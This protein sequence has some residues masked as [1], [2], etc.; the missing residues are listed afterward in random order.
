MSELRQNDLGH[1]EVIEPIKGGFAERPQADG[2]AMP[3]PLPRDDSRGRGL[4]F[5]ALGVLLIVA[6]GVVFLLPQ[7]VE[8]QAARPEPVA[9]DSTEAVDTEPT[10]P[11]LTPE[12]LEQLREEAEAL[13]AEL[14][15]QQARLDTLSAESWGGERWAD[16]VARA[17]VGDDAYLA[18]A[19]QDAVP[20][21]SDTLEIGET[22]LTQ[23]SDIINA[24][25]Q[26][27]A[28]ALEAGNAALATEQFSLV[29]GIEPGNE[30]A[31]R[32]LE[33]AQ[34]LPDVLDF[35]KQ[36]EAFEREGALAEA[37]AAYREALAI[38]A[39]WVPARSALT[40]IEARIR[41]GRFE[42]L[43][44]AGFAALSTEDFD[45]AYERF[46]EALE[47][48]PGSEEAKSGQLQAEQGLRLD[49]IA[50][51]EARAAAFERRELWSRA[52]EQY[53]SAIETDATLVFAQEGLTRARYRDDL[54]SKL[55]YLLGNPNLL[56]DDDVL[57]DAGAMLDEAGAIE[58]AGPR[59]TEQTT[60]L[61]RLVRLAS[62]PV[63]VPLQ[64]DGITEVTVYRVGPLGAFAQTTIEVRPGTYTAIGSRDGYRDV[65]ETFRV[66]PGQT[67]APIRVECV[68]PI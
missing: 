14:L 47:L 35:V 33:R 59:L 43:M 62:T 18:N 10:E 66:L 28:T 4:I 30:T 61:A 49:Q 27:G 19:F 68:E 2:S 41:A 24:A 3:A 57:R 36:A 51:I 21:Y 45:D 7:W 56:F 48:R 63:E 31:Q 37:A 1:D 13:L 46:G 6:I 15:S 42:S 12:E 9:E 67:P 20:A 53:T 58:S 40:A 64:S 32:G 22:L 52:I 29:L 38:D 65:R 16:Y 17:R 5:A 34:R 8:E 39:G 54:D 11:A 23:S 55:A 44:S 25:M 60:E 50:L 26:A